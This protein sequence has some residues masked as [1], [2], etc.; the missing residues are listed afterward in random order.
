[1]LRKIKALWKKIT[2]KHTVPKEKTFSM[3]IEELQDNAEFMH[4]VGFYAL[5]CNLYN[6]NKFDES[7]LWFYIGAIRYRHLLSSVGNDPL[8]PEHELFRLVQLEIGVPIIDYAGENL[9]FWA[10]QIEAANKWDS[11]HLN[12]FYSKRNN[13]QE[14]KD[15]KVKMNKFRLNLLEEQEELT[16]KHIENE[17]KLKLES[18]E[19]IKEEEIE[20]DHFINS[21]DYN[22]GVVVQKAHNHSIAY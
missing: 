20:E 13:R 14:L 1:M 3:D 16:R 18:I 21:L 19:E 12:F 15:I 8:H 2:S 17:H 9:T 11:K 10:E 5:A 4:P 22:A 6:E 7:I